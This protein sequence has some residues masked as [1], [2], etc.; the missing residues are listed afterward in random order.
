MRSRYAKY[1]RTRKETGYRSKLEVQIAA[2]L[3][4]TEAL[5]EPIKIPYTVT[6]FHTYL[7][8]FVLPKQAIIIEGKGEFTAAD[9]K[10]MILVKTQH[11]DLDI[12]IVFSNPNAKIGKKSKTT[13]GDWC[14]KHGFPY[15][16][17]TVPEEWLKHRPNVRQKKALSV[18]LQESYG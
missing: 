12:R 5:Y 15:A 14:E 9:R 11:P 8:D 4:G 16:K 18:F 2:S 6:S 10:K 13:Y 17:G 7:P 3:Q 1:N